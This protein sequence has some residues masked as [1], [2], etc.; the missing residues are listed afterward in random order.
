MADTKT[1]KNFW[2]DLDLGDFRNGGN[3]GINPNGMFTPKPS[4]PYR[5][6][7]PLIQKMKEEEF[8]KKIRERKN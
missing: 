5:P 3:G 7:E 8:K 1:S 2:S 4:N 6:K